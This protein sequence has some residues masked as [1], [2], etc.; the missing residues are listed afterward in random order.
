MRGFRSHDRDRA[1]GLGGAALL[2]AAFGACSSDEPPVPNAT[3]GSNGDP[4][5]RA[6]A[7]GVA[8]RAGAG[9]AGTSV[10]G[11][12]ARGGAAGDGS[13]GDEPGG[14]GEGGALTGGNGGRT[15]GRSGAGGSGG[16]GANGSAGAAPGSAGEGG[17]DDPGGGGE[18]G[19]IDPPSGCS[20]N[21]CLN[22][23]ACLETNG[24]ASCNCPVGFSGE[25]CETDV[26]V[27]FT[28]MSMTNGQICGLLVDGRIDCRGGNLFGQSSPPPGTFVDVSAADHFTCA[29]R[30]GGEIVCFGRDYY[31]ATASPTGTF[32]QLSSVEDEDMCALRTDGTVVCWGEHPLSL[33]GT[34]TQISRS[35]WELCGIKPD[36]TLACVS[37][38]PPTGTFKAV[39]A[40]SDFNCAI[41]TDGTLACWGG[42]YDGIVFGGFPPSGTY[43]SVQVGFSSP[44]YLGYALRDDGAI[45]RFGL[46][47]T[48]PPRI[49][50]RVSPGPFSAVYPSEDRLCVL[51][52]DG[53][54]ACIGSSLQVGP[55]ASNAPS[56]PFL[57]VDVVD[58]NVYAIRNDHSAIQYFRSPS[59][60]GAIS[61][62]FARLSG[63]CGIDL[64]GAP[65]SPSPNTPA[66]TFIDIATQFGGNR[67]CCA[68]RTDGALVCWNSTGQTTPV[69]EPTSRVSQ[70]AKHGC[71]IRQDGTLACWGENRLGQATPPAG[72][73]TRVSVGPN[74]GCA[75]RTDGSL[76]CWGNDD[77]GQ[78]TPPAGVFVDVSAEGAHTCALDA[79]G[80]IR[81]FGRNEVGQ[82]SPPA[83]VFT[84][85]AA[86]GHMTCA[87]STDGIA[88]CFGDNGPIYGLFTF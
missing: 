17:D 85:V 67:D 34:F 84:Q 58:T 23:G 50:T 53:R 71:A 19:S 9:G 74:H 39:S 40:G 87:L 44:N 21:P 27:R 68:V 48:S 59:M 16:A 33:P 76:A 8:G 12:G 77:N 30:T 75:V 54:S 14:A 6:G 88:T 80:T 86:G 4:A 78:A 56:D 81:C 32:S 10:G 66:G 37:R 25:R 7:M 43:Q 45:V 28:K 41:R 15:G 55:P 61:G 49:A 24:V 51:H 29:I 3:A 57:Q 69:A 73:F 22:R 26:G 11:S 82:A 5:G 79:A 31:G 70:S 60:A 1:R 65:I 35:F 47:G 46:D 72:T 2:V 83:G 13:G 38:V 64:V 20:T 52:T 62:T 36:Q 18:G 63:E 42:T